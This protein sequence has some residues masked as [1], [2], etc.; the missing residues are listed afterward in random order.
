MLFAVS[1]RSSAFATSAWWV[2]W[3]NLQV[4]LVSQD[5]PTWA[6]KNLRSKNIWCNLPFFEL[7]SRSS[8]SHSDGFTLLV[9]GYY[10]LALAKVERF[11]R[12]LSLRHV[13]TQPLWHGSFLS[14][15]CEEE[16]KASWCSGSIFF[17]KC[18]PCQAS[19]VQKS[20]VNYNC[21][22]ARSTCSTVSGF[23]HPKKLSQ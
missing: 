21:L 17:V 14:I 23:E 1:I 18:T 11:G 9:T 6:S 13:Q 22:G 10:H 15:K 20:N 3:S 12:Q 4:L 5:F 2:H 8:V 7:S 16:S 19:S